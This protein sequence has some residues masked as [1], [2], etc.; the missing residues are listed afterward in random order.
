MHIS[1]I[2]LSTYLKYGYTEIFDHHLGTKMFP[3]KNLGQL[4]EKHKLI[5]RN[6]P[7][8]V[9]FPGEKDSNGKVAK[10]LSNILAQELR[11]LVDALFNVQY[12]LLIERSKEGQSLS[13][14][15]V[16]SFADF[17]LINR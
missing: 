8:G 14:E 9:R 4:L 11:L 12:P 16:Y 10:S 5:C 15:L 13:N 2:M 7:E 6:W 3:W 1:F 17:D